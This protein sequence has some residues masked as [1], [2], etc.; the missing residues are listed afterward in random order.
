MISNWRS[1]GVEHGEEHCV[2]EKDKNRQRFAWGRGRQVSPAE[3]W[4]YS[5]GPSYP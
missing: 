3:L 5:A 2:A 1:F 4:S